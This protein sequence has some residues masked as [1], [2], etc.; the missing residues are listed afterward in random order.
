[1]ARGTTYFMLRMITNLKDIF[2]PKFIELFLD[3]L[4]LL[5]CF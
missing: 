2:N 3:I 4:C 1:M 5:V